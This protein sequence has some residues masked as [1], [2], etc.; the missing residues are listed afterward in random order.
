MIKR[1]VSETHIALELESVKVKLAVLGGIKTVDHFSN[2]LWLY[3]QR[4]Q[5]HKEEMF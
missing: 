3:F 2:I 1:E 4:K 5:S